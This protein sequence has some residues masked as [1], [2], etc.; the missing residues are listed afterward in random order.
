MS[1]AVEARAVFG[2]RAGLLDGEL[3][4]S[5]RSLVLAPVLQRLE[6]YETS[7]IIGLRHHST[8][9]LLAIFQDDFHVM[10][11]IVNVGPSPAMLRQGPSY[12]RF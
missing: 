8:C 1:N 6:K 2:L 5:T 11:E 7:V 3:Q 12:Q 10:I 9:M 4:C